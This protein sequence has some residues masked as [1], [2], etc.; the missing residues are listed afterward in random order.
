MAH[1][2]KSGQFVRSKKA[3]DH[4][5]LNSDAIFKWIGKGSISNGR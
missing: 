1:K 3:E 5:Q 4:L 2:G